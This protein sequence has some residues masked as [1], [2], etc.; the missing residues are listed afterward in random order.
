MVHH[1]EVEEEELD[2]VQVEEVE[3]MMMEKE[4]ED[5]SQMW[6]HPHC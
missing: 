6:I 3:L 2:D 1:Q 4:L 5:S